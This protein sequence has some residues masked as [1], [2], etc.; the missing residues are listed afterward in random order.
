MKTHNVQTIFTGIL[1]TLAIVATLHYLGR[2]F[3]PLAIAGLLS[4]M[5][6]PLVNYMNR[7]K[8][9]RLIGILLVMSALFIL[10]LIVGRVFYSSIQTFTQVFGI[11]QKRFVNIMSDFWIRLNIPW[12]FFPQFGWTQQMI[13]RLISFTGT[14]VS[15]VTNLGLVLLFLV[16]FM[17]ETPLS[18]RKFRRAFP[19][20]LNLKIGLAIADTTQQVA[21]Y[22]TIKTIIS[23]ITGVLVWISLSLIGQELAALWGLLAF[24]LNYIPN[25]GSLFI[26]IATM[27][28]GLAQFYPNWN[29]VIAVWI[30]IPAIQIILGNIIDPMLQGDRLDL[31][32]IVILISLVLWGW[33]WGITGMFLA[34]PLTVALK[35]ILHHVEYLRPFAVMMGSG[36]MSRSFRRHWRRK[37]RKQKLRDLKSG[38]E[39]QSD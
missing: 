26:M 24:L 34:V 6:T 32:P 13:N 25:L 4:L 18:W 31:S 33:I 36:R 10:L 27:T 39:N 5:L 16:F 30:S 14:F 3:L 20:R 8:I 7:L 22:L 19:L 21:R 17:A 35:I 29:R 38:I 9:P 23:S 2:L 11:Y 28:L 37:I 15:F 1:A 12:E